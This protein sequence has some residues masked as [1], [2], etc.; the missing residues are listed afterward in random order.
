M[1]RLTP[2]RD[3]QPIIDAAQQWI[4][5]C[6]IEDGSILSPEPLWTETNVA[7]VRAAFSDNPH[8][9]KEDFSTKL[10]EQMKSASKSAQRLMAEM[11]WALLLFP[12]NIKVSTKRQ[13][14]SEL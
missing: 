9:G 6:L 4:G 2:K 7:E 13:Q 1:A 12:S 3:F 10:R 5:R 8:E 14:V 11:L